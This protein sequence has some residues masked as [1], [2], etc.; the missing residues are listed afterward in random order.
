VRSEGDSLFDKNACRTETAVRTAA[1]WDR[2]G[3]ER[4][5]ELP[6]VESKNERNLILPAGETAFGEGRIKH[7]IIYKY[8]PFNR[9]LESFTGLRRWR[10]RLG[11]AAVTSTSAHR[12]S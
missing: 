9:Y 12:C 8:R 5:S 11:L 2:T 4:P 7:V 1:N 6:D 10:E 3:T